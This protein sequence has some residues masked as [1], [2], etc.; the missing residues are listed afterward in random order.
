MPSRRTIPNEARLQG[1]QRISALARYLARRRLTRPAKTTSSRRSAGTILSTSGRSGPS[2]TTTSC[3][4][5]RRRR[6]TVN[7]PIMCLTPFRGSNLPTNTMVRFPARAGSG[8]ADG[9]KKLVS[10]PFGIVT[11]GSVGKCG[12]TEST[13]A[14]ETATQASRRSKTRRNGRLETRIRRYSLGDDAVEGPDRDRPGRAPDRRDDEHD[15][16]GVVDVDDVEAPLPE[17]PV[18]RRREPQ[19]PS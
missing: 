9:L 10:M 7:A 6:S 3:T 12:C 14:S 11:N 4:S 18:E 8:S 13:T 2:P 5:S 1:V 15:A 19:L 16:E 17:D